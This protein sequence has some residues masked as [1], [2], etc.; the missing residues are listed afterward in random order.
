VPSTE[1]ATDAATDPTTG[2]IKRSAGMMQAYA[3]RQLAFDLAREVGLAKDSE[4]TDTLRTRAQAVTGL[5][6]SWAEADERARIARGQPLPGSRRPERKTS[7]RRVASIAPI[8][9][10][11]EPKAPPAT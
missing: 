10:E 4:L 2:Q 3:L 7:K 5:I 6:R 1:Y 9:L 11:P 8:S